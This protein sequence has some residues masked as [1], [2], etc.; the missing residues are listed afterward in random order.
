MSQ[1]RCALIT[2]ASL[3]LGAAFARALAAES[4][5]LVLAARSQDQLTTLE[6]EL[7]QAHYVKRRLRSPAKVTT[8][9][10]DLALPDGAD[11][12]HELLGPQADQ[13]DLLINN[14]GFGS[15]GSLAEL[16]AENEAEMIMLNCVSLLKLTRAFLPQMIRHGRGGIINVASTAAF[17]PVPRMA[18]YAAT[19]AFVSSFSQAVN[20]EMRSTG[21]HLLTLCPG[22]TATSFFERAGFFFTLSLTSS[23]PIIIP[24]CL[25][26]PTNFKLKNLS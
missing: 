12:L 15:F 9:A 18:T 13:V 20:C 3:G 1:Y 24:L 14:A 4:V 21:V 7:L 6:H 17:Q 11:Q 10:V 25:A 26:S 16:G 19:K 22:P 23:T 2:G 8:I 5:S